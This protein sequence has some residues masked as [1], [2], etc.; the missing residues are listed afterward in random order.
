M[1][2]RVRRETRETGFGVRIGRLLGI[3]IFAHWSLLVIFAL[4]TVSL[5]AGVFPTWHPDWSLG[6]IWAMAFV[7]ATLFF[8]SI[9]VHELSHAVVGRSQGIPVERIT[10]FI[11]GGMAHTTKEP[12]SA[13]AELLMAAVG[14]VVSL[15]IGIIATLLGS[16]LAFDAVSQNAQTLQGDADS[17]MQVL[18]AANPIATVFLWLGP[19]NILLAVFNMI[20][21]FPLD[22]GRVLRALLWWITGSLKK[23]TQYASAVGQLFAW[24]LIAS[25]I[26]MVFGF[27]IPILGTGFGP[28]LWL[29]LIG[30][31]LHNAARM[32][33]QNV[34]VHEALDEVPVRSLMRSQ[35]QTV[36]P[37]MRIEN[38]V[39]DYFMGYEQRAFPVVRE[40]K[41]MVGLV[42]LDDVRSMPRERWP[43]A[44]VSQIMTPIRDLETMGPQE[45]ALDAFKRLG[46][47]DVDQIPVM[48]GKHLLGMVHRRDI[49]KWLSIH[50]PR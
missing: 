42:C 28:G 46:Y 16:W 37:D 11:F 27:Y 24:V 12:S 9:A 33:Y 38:L 2:E 48:E 19:I 18:A 8:A 45:P 40:D 49:M 26:L 7:A 47:R 6:L 43:D 22:G 41:S 13:K 32:G 44:T 20:P 4:I 14:P 36:S 29:I 30:W 31:F 34:L 17:P 1:T 39:G 35:L 3:D 21:G 23:A 25:G 10:L 15:L 50:T 5:G